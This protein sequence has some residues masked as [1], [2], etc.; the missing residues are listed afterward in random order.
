MSTENFTAPTTSLFVMMALNAW[1]AHN[2]R[3]DNLIAKLTDI[4][5]E[6]PTA[7]ERNTGIY[8][9]G[10]LTAVS[11]RM[12]TLL[13][14][15]T[16]LYPGLEAPFVANPENAGLEKPSLETLKEYWSAVN[17]SL[18]EHFSRMAP[19]EWFERHTAVSEEDFAKEPT[20]NKLNI[21]LSRTNHQS[22]HMG[23]M[24]YLSR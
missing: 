16:Q 15:G 13:G 2:K 18:R 19:E 10:H 14:I 20:R 9:L 3:V 5:M 23:Q 7:P 17:H 1:E 24:A 22:Y 4:Q 6:A 11:D 21:L 8:L 12:H